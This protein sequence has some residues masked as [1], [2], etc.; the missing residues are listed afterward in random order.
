MLY[1]CSCGAVS[2][3]WLLYC[4]R[5]YRAR[6]FR[7]Q[8]RVPNMEITNPIEIIAGRDLLGMAMRS[9]QLPG[10]WADLQ[11]GPIQ[12]PVYLVV[13]GAPGSGKTS[14]G[15]SLTDS[16]PG[17]SIFMA[18]ET[19]IGGSLRGLFARYEI[20]NCDVCAPTSWADILAVLDRNRYELVCIDSLQFL[21]ID[22]TVLRA[23]CIDRG[24]S[25]IAISQTNSE[26]EV[27]GGM[28]ALHACDI[29]IHLP[30]Y[31]RYSVKKNRYNELHE[32]R[33]LK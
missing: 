9:S 11:L 23:A 12:R 8:V 15:L 10:T 29:S 6:S 13:W 19:G 30:E 26:G 31:G 33:W 18:A 5:C 27:R 22:P 1:E 32:G 25:V 28:S 2:D 7:K 4:P 17:E 14:L 20:Q 21:K 3:E 16:W 24:V